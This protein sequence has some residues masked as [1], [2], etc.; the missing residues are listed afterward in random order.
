MI[1]SLNPGRAAHEFVEDLPVRAIDEHLQTK[2]QLEEENT[3]NRTNTI[4]HR[5]KWFPFSSGYVHGRVERMHYRQ[6][7]R[8]TRS[9]L[10]IPETPINKSGESHFQRDLTNKKCVITRFIL[11]DSP[12][13]TGRIR[14]FFSFTSSNSGSP[15]K[16][17]ESPRH[18][19]FWKGKALQS[20]VSTLTRLLGRVRSAGTS[21]SA[22]ERRGTNPAPLFL[23]LCKTEAA[24]YWIFIFGL[25][26]YQWNKDGW[27]NLSCKARKP[28]GYAHQ[29][30]ISA[31]AKALRRAAEGKASA[32]ADAAVWK[33]KYDLERERNAGL[34]HQALASYPRDIY[35]RLQPV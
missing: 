28:S 22:G 17:S 9:V 19:L 1:P 14:L 16:T 33:Q 29:G 27:S 5:I 3:G 34:K 4:T 15:Q 20:D 21:Y 10:A 7:Q 31:V 13:F 23:L 12:F 24:S 35:R 18:P 26:H 2:S 32:Q 25:F 11:E 6:K 30:T 8:D